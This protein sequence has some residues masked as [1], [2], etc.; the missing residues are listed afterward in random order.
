MDLPNFFKYIVLP[1][2]GGF[3]AA[4]G[5]GGGVNEGLIYSP[6]PPP[7]RYLLRKTGRAREHLY[8]VVCPF[9]VVWR[10]ITLVGLL[11]GGFA[12]PRCASGLAGLLSSATAVDEL[13]YPEARYRRQAKEMRRH[14]Y[15]VDYSCYKPPSYRKLNTEASIYM[16]LKHEPVFVDQLDFQ[17]KIY[18]RSG[19][20][21]ETYVPRFLF[22]EEAEATLDEAKLEMEEC[23]VAVLDELFAKTAVAPQQIGILIVNVSTFSPA[24]SHTAWIVNR[25]K[26]KENVKTFNVS[27]MGCSA[28]VIAIDMVKDMFKVSSD[29]Y[30]VVVGTENITLNANYMGN[31]KSMMLTNCLFRVGGYALLLS[32]KSGD[33]SRAKMKLLHTVRTNV[34]ADDTSYGSVICK[35]DAE[36]NTG[37]S[38]SP[39]LI[40]VAGKAVTNNMGSLGPK[41]LPLSEQLYYV[42]NVACI[43]ILKMN[44][45]PY[46]PNFRLAFH[47]F[48]IHPGGRAV[49]NGIGKNLKLTDHDLEPSRMSLHRF[50][51]TSTS[52]L[53]YES[54]YL[55]AK[56]LYKVGDRMWQISLGS[57][58]KCNSAVWEILRETHHSEKTVW[59]DCIHRYPCNTRNSF[60]DDYVQQWLGMFKH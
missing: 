30:A 2:D 54:A 10:A 52:G 23:F 15:L 22:N 8:D 18:L 14:C 1:V 40:D 27:G 5:R 56:R 37:I 20:G 50:G 28:G 21:E 35:E 11:A 46:I 39:S 3:P 31:D 4:L 60:T 32:N 41:V 34:A 53:W 24:P 16:S 44:L 45:K 36:G 57:G 19:L 7:C 33:A 58:F 38:L 43:K 25:Y 17:W 51:N 9:A 42:Y 59:D 13:H 29:S 47:H 49:V 12:Y 48:C 26:M 6:T 55:E